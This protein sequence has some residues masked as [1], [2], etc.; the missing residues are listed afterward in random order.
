MTRV[1]QINKAIFILFTEKGESVRSIQ[2]QLKSYGIELT[3]VEILTIISSFELREVKE[4]HPRPQQVRRAQFRKVLEPVIKLVY[5]HAITN[6]TLFEWMTERGVQ[7][8]N[9][10]MLTKAQLDSLLLSLEYKFPKPRVRKNWEKEKFLQL[11]SDHLTQEE[12][13]VIERWV[14]NKDE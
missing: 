6:L 9:S 4:R 1:E 2:S 5:E 8:P 13:E 7:P 10:D 11:L 12:E 3:M 14:R